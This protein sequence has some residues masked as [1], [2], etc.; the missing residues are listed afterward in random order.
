MK[1]GP[2]SAVAAL[3]KWLRFSGLQRRRR[4]SLRL[5][6]VALALRGPPLQFKLAGLASRSSQGFHEVRLSL[7]SSGSMDIDIAIVVQTELV[8]NRGQGLHVIVS[9]L[10]WR[11]REVTLEQNLLLGEVRDHQAVGVRNRR[12]MVN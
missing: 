3:Y 11:Q 8:E 12:D 6:A 9:W 4:S 1:E 2:A 7:R 5:R 10:T